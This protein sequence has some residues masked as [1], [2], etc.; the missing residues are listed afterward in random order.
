M[1]EIAKQLEVAHILEGSVQKAGNAV[2]INVQL[3]RAATDAHLWGE[4]YDR[5]L[6]NIFGVEAEV[7][8]AIADDVRRTGGRAVVVAGDHDYGVQLD[9]QLRLV[10]GSRIEARPPKAP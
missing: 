2:H 8:K 1:R 5:E 3:I 9:G 10:P 7:A 4:S 6:Q